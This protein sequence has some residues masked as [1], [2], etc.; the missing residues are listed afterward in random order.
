VRGA[1]AGVLA[2]FVGLL[3]AMLL[4]LGGAVL[5]GPQM[6]A[7]AAAAFVATRWFALDITW[8]FAG[9]LALWGLLLAAGLAE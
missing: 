3:A 9:G 2:A 8:V 6:L 7:L 5:H 1:L 4:Q